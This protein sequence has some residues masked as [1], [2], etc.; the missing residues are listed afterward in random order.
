[1]TGTSFTDTQVANGRLYSYNVVAAGASSACYG[2]ASNCSQV[3]P[4]AGPPVPDFSVS[5]SPSSLTVTQGSN[6]T[7]TC[8]VTSTGGFA[9]A[10]NLSC[11]GLPAGVSCSFS[12]NPVTPPANGTVNSTVTV[13]ATAGATTGTSNISVNGVNGATTR[14]ASLSL[15]VNPTGGGGGAQTA[16]F[17]SALQAPKCGT[18][19]ISCDSGAS[20]L[21]GRDTLASGSEPNQPNTI[22][23]SCADGTSGTFHV[24]ESNDRIKVS[25]LDGTDFAPGKSVRIDATVWAWTT[26]SSDRLD[27]YFAANANSPVWTFLTSLTPAAAGAQTLSATYTLPTGTLQAVRAR[28]RYQGTAASCGVGSFNDHDDLIFAVNP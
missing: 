16:V 11:S 15:T 19:G 14:S 28:F 2:R 22:A 5:C 7:S 24:D 21:L 6:T 23:D 17:D 3:T 4:V 13:A 20:L 1:M 8:T 25:T 18:V 12:A 10:V 27:L 9:G 26:P